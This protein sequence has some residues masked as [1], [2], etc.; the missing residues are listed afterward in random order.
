MTEA[1]LETAPLKVLLEGAELRVSQLPGRIYVLDHFQH[2]TRAILAAAMATIW[3][4]PG[5]RQPW[6]L[7]VV[8]GDA[9][10][11]ATYD[12]D[13][14]KHEIPPDD[15]RAVGT[16]VV[17]NKQLHRAVIGAMGIAFKMVSGFYLS[18]HGVLGD[19]VAAQRELITK[20]EARGKPF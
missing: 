10:Y 16:A 1:R 13:I 20:A 3:K 11:D 18:A 17:T 14:R 4:S 12:G 15:K 19:A 8:M 2:L 5:W 9:S 7:V 6:G